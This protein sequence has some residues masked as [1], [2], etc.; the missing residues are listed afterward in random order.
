M[1]LRNLAI[2][3]AVIL[4]ALAVYVAVNRGG[5]IAAPGQNA[6]SARAQDMTYSE[7]LKARDAGEIAAVEANGEKLLVQMK[8]DRKFE[9][10]TTLTQDTVFE[11]EAA[12]ASDADNCVPGAWHDVPEVSICDRPA[13]PA[14]QS[15]ITLPAG[16]VAGTVCAGTIPCRPD[17]FVRVVPTSGDT[18]NVRIVLIRQ[19]PMI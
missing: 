8:D 6:Q 14:A 7:L 5:P 4:G 2:W 10:V 19:G 12:P 11:V 9:V 1:N 17:A 16:T 3:G 13:V 18:A 15:R